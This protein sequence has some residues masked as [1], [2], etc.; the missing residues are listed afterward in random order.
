MEKKGSVSFLF[1]YLQKCERVLLELLCHEPCRPLQRLSSSTVSHE[2]HAGFHPWDLLWG[3]ISIPSYSVP[4]G[5]QRR[6]RPDADPRQAAGEAL[7]HLQQPGG[8]RR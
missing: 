4:I 7:P 3:Q 1:Y 5:E 2:P 8:I 6:H